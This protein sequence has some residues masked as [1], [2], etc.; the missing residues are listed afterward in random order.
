M[1]SYTVFSYSENLPKRI[2]SK[3]P[4]ELKISGERDSEILL[5]LRIL[6]GNV[7]LKHNYSNKKIKS[8][9]NYFS[10]DLISFPNWKINFPKLFSEDVTVKDLADFIAKEKFK[11]KKFYSGI[12]S[13]LSHFILHEEK[14]SHTSSFIYIYRILENISYAFPLIYSSKSHDF[15]RSFQHLKSLMSNDKEKKELGFFKVFIRTLYE[16][17]SISD[18]SIDIYINSSDGEVGKQ[19][20]NTLKKFSDGGV[21]HGDSVEFDKFS[22]KF[23][24]MG[25]F[26]VGIRNR[27]FHNLNGS[28]ENIDSNMIVDSDEFFKF[29]NPAAMYW[30]SMVFIEI[31]IYSLSEF[32]SRNPN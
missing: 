19:M 21:L 23:C 8:K 5:I 17:N 13:E 25:S 28:S 16:E 26:I 7:E 2:L 10:S 29:I 3:L 30:F 20:Y 22:I 4:D 18:T 15:L 24:E 1:T 14:G 31:I 27:F 12:L 6:S 11:N 9:N 32:Q